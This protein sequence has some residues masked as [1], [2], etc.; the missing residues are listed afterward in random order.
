MEQFDAE[1]LLQAAGDAI[2]AADTSGHIVFWNRAAERMFGHAESEALGQSL[3]LIIP[4][5]LQQRH[6]DG[7]QTVMQTGH[8]RYGSQV[9]RV[10]AMHKDGRGLSIA[11]TVA[12]LKAPDGRVRSIAAII[13][14][15]TERW[16]EERA[17]RRRITELE[18]GIAH[19]SGTPDTEKT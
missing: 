2:V 19:P 13:R 15:E 7:Y 8:T 17:L 1:S 18:A 10:P 6:W 4:Q 5:R 11:F 14:D 12:L 9:L 3:D 16:N